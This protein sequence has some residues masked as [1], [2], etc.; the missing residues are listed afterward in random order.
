MEEENLI[1]SGQLNFK[2]NQNITQQ[3]LSVNDEASKV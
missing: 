2:V 1:A 3:M